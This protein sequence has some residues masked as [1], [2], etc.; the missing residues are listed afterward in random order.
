MGKELKEGGEEWEIK[1]RKKEK[2]GSSMEDQ[3][4]EKNGKWREEKR[5]EQELSEMEEGK[6]KKEIERKRRKSM[7]NRE[8]GK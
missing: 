6:N 8:K 1:R 3:L 2:K 4:L 5:K 7:G